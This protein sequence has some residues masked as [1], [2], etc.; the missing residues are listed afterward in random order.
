MAA[1]NAATQTTLP[2]MMFV[3][4]VWAG[5]FLDR[6][7]P[8]QAFKTMEALMA[9]LPIQAQRNK[10]LPLIEW[11]K[12]VCVREGP[13]AAERRVS[14]LEIPCGRH[15]T[16]WTAASFSGQRGGWHHIG[17]QCRWP[18]QRQDCQWVWSHNS[19]LPLQ[20]AQ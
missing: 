4:K 11:T 15:R 18:Q 10:A 5:Y 9:T 3:P 12:A 7:T 19:M 1:T 13:G 14:Q 2:R 8:Y 6:K 17:P 20:L 16:W